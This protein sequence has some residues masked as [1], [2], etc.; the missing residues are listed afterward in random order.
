MG[1]HD[2]RTLPRRVDRRTRGGGGGGGGFEKEP[3]DGELD[4]LLRSLVQG[5]G[6]LVEK[7]KGGVLHEGTRDAHLLLLADAQLGSPWT[8]G[9]VEWLIG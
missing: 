2:G 4:R 6:G 3:I 7:E 8:V 5:R 1:H 9:L